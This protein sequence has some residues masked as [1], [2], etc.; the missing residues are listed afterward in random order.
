MEVA[1]LLD[2]DA[3]QRIDPLVRR[4]ESS[5][6]SAFDKHIDRILDVASKAYRAARKHA[7]LLRAVDF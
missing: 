1:F 4:E 2:S 3:I 7:Y 5:V 6:L